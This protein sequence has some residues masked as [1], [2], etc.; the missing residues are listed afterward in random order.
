MKIPRLVALAAV[1]A[2][3]L[4]FTA[5]RAVE[6]P[7]I[8]QLLK[9]IEELDQKVK[10]LEGQRGLDPELEQKVRILERRNELKEEEAAERAKST[11][12]ITMGSGGLAVSSAD[13]NFVM[14]VRG[15]LQT[16]G[17]FFVS[18]SEANDTFL[19]RRVRPILEGTV[20]GKFDYRLMA[21]FASGVTQ[22]TANNGSILDAYLNARLLPGFQIQ[23]GKFKEPVGLERLQSWR[24]LLFVE[25]GFPTQLVPNRDTGVMLHGGLWSNALY[26][27]VGAFNGT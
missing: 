9:R 16:D 10:V 27:Q 26:Y 7:T 12:A 21:D 24:N 14:R 8:E 3:V 2:A 6:A 13:S 1:I 18:D 20:F 15:G 23:A 17:R 22:T 4:P 11:P 25:R 19:L 5:A